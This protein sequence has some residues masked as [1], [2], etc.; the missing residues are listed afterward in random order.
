MIVYR[1]EDKEGWGAFSGDIVWPEEARQSD[2][3]IHSHQGCSVQ[4]PLNHVRSE[5][6]FGC[7]SIKDIKKYWGDGF[8]AFMES[9]NFYLVKYKVRKNYVL[10]GKGN[11]ELAFKIEK[12]VKIDE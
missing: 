11:F 2:N 4:F 7:K 6:R 9:E 12:A 5:Y 10:L 1:I 8:D 3:N